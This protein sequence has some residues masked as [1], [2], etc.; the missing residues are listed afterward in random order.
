VGEIVIAFK[1]AESHAD[2]QSHVIY[3]LYASN[4]KPLHSAFDDKH[5]PDGDI[6]HGNLTYTVV[7]S[8]VLGN[9]EASP[10]KI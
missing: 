5:L 8:E 1:I 3:P 6:E 4:I 7:L 9:W 10:N 2:R